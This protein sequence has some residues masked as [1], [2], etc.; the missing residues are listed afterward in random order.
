MLSPP[1]LAPIGGEPQENSRIQEAAGWVGVQ[2]QNAAYLYQGKGVG[3]REDAV[4][5]LRLEVLLGPCYYYSRAVLEPFFFSL[6]LN[7]D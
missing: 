4:N 3:W 5:S 6:V 7:T 1:P 2:L